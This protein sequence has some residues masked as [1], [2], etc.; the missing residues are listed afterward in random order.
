MATN[1]RK[2]ADTDSPPV[3]PEEQFKANL[4]HLLFEARQ[5]YR[6][7][8]EPWLD[9]DGLKREIAERRGGVSETDLSTVTEKATPRGSSS[10]L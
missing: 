2:R 6:R 4:D 8:G 7:S 10:N 1:A 9:W 5:E 3:T